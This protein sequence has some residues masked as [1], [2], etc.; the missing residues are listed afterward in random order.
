MEEKA[1]AFYIL[2]FILHILLLLPVAISQAQNV[3]EQNTVK[4]ECIQW[5]SP[6]MIHSRKVMLEWAWGIQEENGGGFMFSMNYTTEDQFSPSKSCLENVV[7]FT[8]C[9]VETSVTACE[10]S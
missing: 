1:K 3:A 8:V 7:L 9:S 6:L 2:F 5:F 4:N 10:S